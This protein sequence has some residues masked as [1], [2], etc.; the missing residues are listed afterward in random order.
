VGSADGPCLTRA[1][2]PG[3]AQTGEWVTDGLTFFL[4]DVSDEAN[5]IAA[6]T[7]A[8]VTISVEQRTSLRGSLTPGE[9]HRR[10]GELE[11]E[12]DALETGLRRAED[13]RRQTSLGLKA[14][15]VQAATIVQ[16]QRQDRAWR[17]MLQMRKAHT[18]LVRQRSPL[19]FLKWLRRLRQE[20]TEELAAYERTNP[21]VA[22]YIPPSIHEPFYIGRKPAGSDVVPVPRARGKYDVV[23]L[24]VFEFDFRRQRPQQIAAEF[25]RAGHRVFW[26]SPSRR[27]AGSA[28]H[29]FEAVQLRE[30]LWEVH[31]EPLRPNIYT[32][33]LD[34]QTTAALVDR[35]AELFKEWAISE[36]TVVVQLPYW[37]AVASGLRERLGARMVFDCMDDW[38]SMPGISEFNRVEERALVSEAD[39]VVLTA[40]RLHDKYAAQARSVALVP[41]AVEFEA[42]S[43]PVEIAR[44]LDGLPRPIVGYVGAIA[45]W[46]DYDL[47]RD[48]IVARPQYSFVF[49]GA[50]GLEQHVIGE[51]IA[52]FRELPNVRLL[53]HKSYQELPAYVSGFDVCTIPFVINEVT[54]STDPV[55]IYEYFSLGRPVVTT[56]MPE[57]S[58]RL[59]LLYVGATPEEFARQL[60]AAVAEHGE[61]SARRR[62]YAAAN[63]WSDRVRTIDAAVK[64]VYPLVSILIVT[65]NSLEFVDC[66]LDSVL[67]NTSYPNFEVIIADNASS[68][69]TPDALM[70]WADRDSRIRVRCLPQNL[71]FAGANNAIAR[72]AH[73]S[74]LILL[75]IDT[76]VTPG[77]VGRL[78]G[79][80]RRDPTIGQ[81]VAVTNW[82]GN[83]AK[84]DVTYSNL[85]EMEGFALRRARDFTGEVLELAVAPL[86]CTFIPMD[87]W[88]TVGELDDSFEIGMFEDDDYSLRIHRSGRRVVTAE[89]CFIHH[90]GR[91]S[92][93]KLPTDEY[94]LVFERNLRR[95]EQKW[96]VVWA[97][98]RTRPGTSGEH[99]AFE[100]GQFTASA[101]QELDSTAR[102]LSRR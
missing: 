60:D 24:P 22:D 72:E 29:G 67:R 33:S 50:L 61:L 81:V 32:E 44:E 48:V 92:F 17:L 10:I 46:F 88:R 74:Y 73:G 30:N 98:H 21:V 38:E 94:R 100:V 47:M 62:A 19:A 16:Q 56:P 85:E 37:R 70:R 43:A 49:V 39:L 82:A 36:S 64:A 8:T 6:H 25:A 4:Q 2:A 68:D 52:R 7:L 9:A 31:V 99:A 53:G 76:V 40:R 11:S 83:E 35:L 3:S 57:L 93:G 14:F 78:M 89:D 41:N 96:G 55:K 58:D 77:W 71:G 51:E 80:H 66:C 86:F 23:I 15:A 13:V 34:R 18:L 69:Q 90:F 102:P 54:R 84:L 65:H 1:V 87:V 101:R 20:T 27:P 42:F 79:P 91:G 26:V 28:P 45:A 5:G 59:D 97:P 63:T 75:N 95:F 12:V